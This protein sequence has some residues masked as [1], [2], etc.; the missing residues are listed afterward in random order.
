MS[1]P[2]VIYLRLLPTCP[3]RAGEP[4]SPPGGRGCKGSPCPGA[5]SQVFAARP[6]ILIPATS[7]GRA[8]GAA[9]EPLPGPV[10][11]GCRGLGLTPSP[12]SLLGCRT[13]LAATSSRLLQLRALH[14]RASSCPA[15]SSCVGAKGAAGAM[16][17]APSCHQSCLQHQA[18]TLGLFCVV[19][20]H[21]RRNCPAPPHDSSFRTAFLR[22]SAGSVGHSFIP[23]RR[24]HHRKLQVIHPISISHQLK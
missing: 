20:P 2:D 22:D 15:P 5:L 6:R 11:R 12:P 7:L 16:G 4:L 8:A 9:T 10:P 3:R 1:Q 23:G 21:R 19:K 13:P 17:D 24:L 18:K 14:P